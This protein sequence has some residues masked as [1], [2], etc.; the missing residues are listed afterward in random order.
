[1]PVERAEVIRVLREHGLTGAA[2]AEAW[3]TAREL[4]RDT[5]RR[6][7]EHAA[8]LD[9]DDGRPIGP[10]LTGSTSS[11]DL[12]PHIERF[13]RG[14]R[15][16]QIHTHPRST[17][18]SNLDLLILGSHPSVRAMAVVGVDGA[19]HVVSR[20]VETRME[21]SRALFDG[22]LQEL[23]RLTREHVPEAERPHAAMLRVA[24]RHNLRYDREMGPADER[25]HP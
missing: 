14:R 22:F 17:S 4:V 1:M 2:A 6:G 15:Y 3:T 18:F 5:R 24:A 7:I 10:V 11:T 20:L 12:T 16:V 25:P 19:W 21:N 9:A 8:T 23:T 13:A